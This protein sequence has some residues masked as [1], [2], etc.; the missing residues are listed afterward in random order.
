MVDSSIDLDED[1]ASVLL[2]ESL[3]RSDNDDTRD[4]LLGGGG[5]EDDVSELVVDPGHESTDQ[6]QQSSVQSSRSGDKD[7][8]S[9]SEVVRPR[10]IIWRH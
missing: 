6:G 2:E 4:G 3:I 5:H 10:R 8:P 1:E 7:G 9:G